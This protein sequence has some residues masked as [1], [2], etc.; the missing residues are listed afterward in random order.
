MEST[1][2]VMHQI[3][4]PSE[5]D[6]MG[7]CFGGQVR[8]GGGLHVMLLHAPVPVRAWL[9]QQLR[10]RSPPPAR[11]PARPGARVPRC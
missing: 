9:A 2:V 8:A 6:E 10:P 11:P 4:P 7:I 3:V 5:C 1:R